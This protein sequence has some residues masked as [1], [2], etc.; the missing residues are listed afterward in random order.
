MMGS[1]AK[2]GSKEKRVAK[3]FA[4]HAARF[5]TQLGVVLT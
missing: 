3:R 4:L 1:M 5:E 2:T